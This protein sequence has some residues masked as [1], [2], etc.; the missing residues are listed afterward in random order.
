MHGRSLL[1]VAWVAYLPA[2]RPALGQARPASAGSQWG[3][4]VR[5]GAGP[6]TGQYGDLRRD[7]EH[8]Y[9]GAVG[10]LLATRYFAGPRVSLG[11]EATIESQSIHVNYQQARP[12][13]VYHPQTLNQWRLFVPLYLRTASPASW[14]HLLVGGGPTFALGQ[15]G[16]D[17][18]YYPRTVE[19][20]CVLG[21][22]V[23]L[24][25]WHRYETTLGLRAHAPLTPSYAYGFP[26][27]SSLK[28]EEQAD[29]FTKWFGFT[30][31]TT[32]YPAA[33]R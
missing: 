27:G 29:V 1:L 23:R 12:Y 32:L 15:P 13:P 18:A 8:H 11:L 4:G 7:Y 3:F 16:A 22:E 31:G 9:T 33:R 24:L 6:G 19:Y 10:S 5:G 20:T 30:L 2:A 26:P 25:P 14:L 21:L 28:N 17:A